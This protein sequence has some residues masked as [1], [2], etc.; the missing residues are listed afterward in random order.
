MELKEAFN[1]T[2]R[3]SK[4]SYAS[5]SGL[6]QYIQLFV[7]SNGVNTKYYANNRKQSFKQTFFWADETNQ[8][9]TKLESFADA[10][11]EPCHIA[12][13][14]TR[15][16]VL[17][18]TDKMLMALRPYQYYATEAIIDRV[19]N[20]D[21]NGYIWHTTGS[22]KTLTSFKT[23]QILT[24]MPE[25]D[26]VVFV[27]DR[28]DLDYQTTKEFNS[29]SKGSIDGTD[30]TGAL[31]KQ[32]LGEPKLI[33]TTIQKLNTAISKD[34]YLAEMQPI[35][36]KKI[37]FIFDECHR[38]QFGDTHKRIVKFFTN[39]QMFGFTGTPILAE[40]NNG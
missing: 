17:N 38:S 20:T 26:K 19:K 11:L 33:V 12:K 34:R 7:I 36:G 3:Y 15:Y 31:V 35:Q 18:E 13:M 30:N 28:K 4:H 10:F 8:N 37:I 14:I 9:I 39:K 27:V 1:Q 32:L 22:G 24:R 2:H 5:G 16:I 6:F 23:S 29:F 21:K 25:V 40:N